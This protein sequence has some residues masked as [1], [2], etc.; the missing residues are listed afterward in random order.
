[1]ARFHRRG[2][3]VP[4]SSL[5]RV[6]WSTWCKIIKEDP[7][8]GSRVLEID[9]QNFVSYP[10]SSPPNKTTKPNHSNLSVLGRDFVRRGRERLEDYPDKDPLNTKGKKKGGRS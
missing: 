3:T 6:N 9:G 1:M 2:G 8:T 10:V 5:R 7:V 4:A